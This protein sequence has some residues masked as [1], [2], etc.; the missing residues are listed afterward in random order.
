[1]RSPQSR[2]ALM[3]RQLRTPAATLA[4]TTL[5]LATMTVRAGEEPVADLAPITPVAQTKIIDYRYYSGPS[6]SAFRLSP[7][8][9]HAVG[10][11][12]GNQLLIY[13]TARGPVNRQP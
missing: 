2:Y 7:D 11:G 3:T 1:M 4:L 10:S 8:G 6:S 5:A 12:G 9:K 13:N